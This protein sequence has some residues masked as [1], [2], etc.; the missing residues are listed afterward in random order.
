MAEFHWIGSTGNNVTKFYWNNIKNWAVKTNEGFKLATTYGRLPQGNDT[1][2]IGTDL[3]CFSP[4]LYGG[5]SGGSGAFVG[6]GATQG[7]GWWCSGQTAG[8]AHSSAG[9]TAG[10]T[11]GGVRFIVATDILAASDSSSVSYA[12]TVGAIDANRGIYPGYA[13]D[14]WGKLADLST[15]NG[16]TVESMLM[17]MLQKVNPHAA[18][19]G[20]SG[21]ATLTTYAG[22]YPFPMLGGGL[23]GDTLK[24][25]KDIWNVSYSRGLYRNQSTGVTFEGNTTW[26]SDHAWIGGGWTGDPSLIPAD[27]MNGLRVRIGGADSRG[28]QSALQIFPGDGGVPQNKLFNVSVKVV[29]DKLSGSNQ[30]I[31]DALI[32]SRG[33]PLHSYIL[34]G[35]S[36]RNIRSKGDAAIN[37]LGCTAGS[38][39]VDYHNY[40]AV[41]PRSVLGGLVVDTD[42]ND[43]RY[44]PWVLYYAGGITSGARNAV[45]GTAAFRIDNPWNTKILVQ[46]PPSTYKTTSYANGMQNLVW[47]TSNPLIAIGDFGGTA[48]PRFDT[49]DASGQYYT[50]APEINVYSNTSFTPVGPSGP[51]VDASCSYY[52]EFLGNAVVG[53]ME[54]RGTNLYYSS[55]AK[56]DANVYIGTLLMSEGSVL[57]L[58]RNPN[59]DNWFIGGTTGSSGQ[60][61]GG[62]ISQDDTCLIRPSQGSQLLNNKIISNDGNNG[63]DARASNFVQAN[64]PTYNNNGTNFVALRETASIQGWRSGIDND[65]LA[66]SLPPTAAL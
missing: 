23:T 56:S 47:S 28:T 24:Y 51:E 54:T 31:T 58:S 59:M 5:Y 18:G 17:D 57:D 65:G 27:A 4:L 44:H 14:I 39:E 15:Q 12:G 21:Q 20:A 33:N 40:T 29:S 2:K 26:K 9:Y 8:D 52:V 25:L 1:V 62:I 38:V 66:T 16:R 63:F 55:Q 22:K 41:S 42:N 32:D 3:H 13:N 53:K 34:D 60:F 48:G 37:I 45:F 43:P 64:S 61:V 30:I 7:A 49:A 36:F 11:G 6:T 10:V 19:I 50:T 46:P 35:G